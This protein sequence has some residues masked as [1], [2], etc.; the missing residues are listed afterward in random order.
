[1]SKII[2]CDNQNCATEIP[3]VFYTI[4]VDIHYI[5][6]FAS[7]NN[8]YYDLCPQCY[9]GLNLPFAPK[10]EENL[11]LLDTTPAEFVVAEFNNGH[12]HTEGVVLSSDGNGS[13]SF[14]KPY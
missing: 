1:M 7:S 3:D 8:E 9:D 2:L 14:E 4:E 13:S 11:K 5:Q 10:H 6:G 12:A